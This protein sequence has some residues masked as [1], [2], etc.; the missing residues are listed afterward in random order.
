MPK[1]SSSRFV[2]GKGGRNAEDVSRRAKLSGGTYDRYLSSDVQAFKP[3]EGE[4]TIRILP[5]TWL[6]F[7]E[8][9][10]VIENEAFKKYGND[11][12]IDV[13]IHHNVGPDNGTY[14]C[15]D[16]MR[17]ERCPVC[18]ARRKATDEDE[19]D[20]LSISRRR[21]AWVIDR[22]NEK[23]GPQLW[24]MPLKQVANEINARSTD[25]KSGAVLYIDDPE[26]GYDVLLDREGSDKRTK[27]K[28]VEID[29][30]P[31]PLHDK[32]DLM[33]RWLD[34][35]AEHPLPDQLVFFE[36]SHIEKVLFGQVRKRDEEEEGERPS[37]SRRRV[38]E[39][40]E[41]EEVDRPRRSRRASAEPEE[42]EESKEEEEERPS[43]SRRERVEETEEEEVERPSRSRRRGKVEEEEE[44]EEE[45]KPTR[46][47]RRGK[48]EEEELEEEEE[49]SKEEEEE[50]EEEEKPARSARRALRKLR[51]K[52][53]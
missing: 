40:E 23:A 15:L 39:E 18:E 2:Y 28:G 52:R 38:V 4:C 31:T 51:G 9:G 46:S 16:K 20:A 24:A 53:G 22:D 1:K 32:E 10:K 48:D 21:L 29:R 41:E 37:R 25:K 50:E 7:D 17:G 11:W 44:E 8:K 19:M 3:R 49:E 30:D 45:D 12:A 5:P 26:N 33:D 6:D 35:I 34:Y 36:A 47:R 42:E 13:F 43:R 27:Y 14:L